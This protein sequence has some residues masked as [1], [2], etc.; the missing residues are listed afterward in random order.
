MEQ[1]GKKQKKEMRQ[2][3]C[4]K[5]MQQV[6][7]EQQEQQEQQMQ[8]VLKEQQ[9]QQ[10]QQMH[11]EVKRN[12][13]VCFINVLNILILCILVWQIS[14]L[15]KR[16]TQTKSDDTLNNQYEKEYQKLS[17]EY[18]KLNG[19]Y[20]K[21]SEEYQ[22]LENL[23]DIQLSLEF[24]SKMKE[25]PLYTSMEAARRNITYL[26]YD[27]N[28]FIFDIGCTCTFNRNE[29]KKIT[30]IS[31]RNEERFVTEYILEE[32][33]QQIASKSYLFKLS[34]CSDEIVTLAVATD[35]KTVYT[36][37]AVNVKE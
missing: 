23:P 14:I 28:E 1:K 11:Q 34:I 22:K 5:Q 10:E 31:V 15:V 6:L 13:R 20:Q 7:K 17:E 35:K 29:P 18:K 8:Q 4:M 12:R 21:L 36:S 27:K 25:L 3:Q 33:A 19:D 37:V 24:D 2:E 9:E 32:D 16:P 26:D 30:K